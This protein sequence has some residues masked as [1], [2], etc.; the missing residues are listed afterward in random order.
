MEL[1][2]GERV[3][4]L[5]CLAVISEFDYRAKGYGL[6]GRSMGPLNKTGTALI[7]LRGQGAHFLSESRLRVHEVSRTLLHA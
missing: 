7:R 6:E 4:G 1:D 2:G 5:F 3:G